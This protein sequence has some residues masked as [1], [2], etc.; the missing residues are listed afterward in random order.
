MRHLLTIAQIR[1]PLTQ[2][3]L[4]MLLIRLLKPTKALIVIKSTIPIGHT[5]YLQSR[6]KTDRIVFSP[7]F[8][9]EGNALKDNLYPSRI[10]VGGQCAKSKRFAEILSD[11]AKEKDIKILHMPSKEIESVKLFSNTYLTMR[12]SFLTNWI[13]LHYNQLNTKDIIDGMSFDKRIGDTYNNPSLGYGGYCLPKDTK[14][15]LHN[16]KDTP[17]NLIEAIVHSNETRKS[18]ISKQILKKNLKQ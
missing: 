14:Q 8:L 3:L 12:V 9:R 13:R 5:E 6:F 10:I 11:S 2:A 15:L 4:I 16:F 1:C 18:F 7:E 17:Q